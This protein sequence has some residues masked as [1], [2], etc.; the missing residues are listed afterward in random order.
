MFKLWIGMLGVQNFFHEVQLWSLQKFSGQAKYTLMIV[1]LRY[2]KM[3]YYQA[4]ESNGHLD[5]SA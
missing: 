4:K 2:E 5:W 3:V 1:I